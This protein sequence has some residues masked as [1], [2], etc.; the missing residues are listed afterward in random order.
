MQGSQAFFRAVGLAGL[1]VLG[2]GAM[3]GP[4]VA[5]PK[6]PIKVDSVPTRVDYDRDVRPIISENCFK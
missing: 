6:L 2:V 4:P 5:K 3:A 1:M